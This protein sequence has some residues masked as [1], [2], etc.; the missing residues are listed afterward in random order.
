LLADQRPLEKWPRCGATVRLTFPSGYLLDLEIHP[1]EHCLRLLHYEFGEPILLGTM[2]CHQMSDLFRWEEFQAVTQR[3]KD[4][5]GPSWAHELLLSFY[6]AITEDCADQHSEVLQK[7]LLESMV[8]SAEEIEYIASYTRR[9]GTRRDFR[10]VE[11][12]ELGWMADGSD[13][14]SMRRK[15][16]DFNFKAFRGFL[17]AVAQ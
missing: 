1:G 13:A 9:A 4:N 7:D 5:D 14:Y 17:A 11:S 10:W 16:S 15:D 3:L 2:D 6:V 12:A 8:F